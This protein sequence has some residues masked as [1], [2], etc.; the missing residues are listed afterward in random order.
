MTFFSALPVRGLAERHMVAVHAVIVCCTGHRT[1]YLPL[2]L[3]G[4]VLHVCIDIQI[5]HFSRLLVSFILRKGLFA[6]HVERAI[7]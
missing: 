1:C 6:N 4:T 2:N 3:H 5:S 7:T